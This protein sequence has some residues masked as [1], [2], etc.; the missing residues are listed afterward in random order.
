MASGGVGNAA[1]SQMDQVTQ[2]NAANAEESASAS[3]ELSA[4]A[5]SMKEVVSQLVTLVGGAKSQWIHDG[6][7]KLR[8][9]DKSDETFHRIAVRSEEP[10]RVA[11]KL[12][13][14]SIP[15]DR[16]EDIEEFNS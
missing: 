3:E 11:V 13:A 14:K 9:F 5:E 15:L 10:E 7:G 8:T 16:Y 2:K 6:R 4:Q 1:I 12:A